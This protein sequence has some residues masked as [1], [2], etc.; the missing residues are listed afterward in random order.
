MT[1]ALATTKPGA[2]ALAGKA[3]DAAAAQYIFTDYRSRKA[4]ETIRRQDADLA[5]FASYLTHVGVEA[6]D[7]SQ[8][9]EAWRGVSW[10]VVSGFVVWQLSQGYAVGSVNVRLSTV[11]T[12]CKLAMLAGTISAETYAMIRAVA[13][14]RSAEGKRVDEQREQT[15]KG[16]KKAQAVSISRDQAR[17]LKAQPNTPQG[18]RDALLMC[19]LLDHGLR[20]GEV[21]IL[22]VEDFDLEA[23]TF[24]FYRPK[25]D[26]VQTH[27]MRPDTRKAATAYLQQDAPATGALWLGSRKGGALGGTIS[28]RNLSERV[29]DLGGA[30]GI[31]GLSPHDCRHAWATLASRNGTPIKA[32]QDAGGWSS[33]AMPL[34]YAESAE[35]AND[36]VNLD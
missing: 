15:R 6:G 4:A 14:Y 32:L 3:A 24:T 27:R 18:R 21:S 5:L 12:F 26:K 30:A 33:P 9:A 10:G 23:G 2:L 22:K 1:D 19:L 7:L 34:R 29:T 25:V 36:G 17:K 8:D 11:K 20:I 31:A 13:G 35:I 28:T 16:V